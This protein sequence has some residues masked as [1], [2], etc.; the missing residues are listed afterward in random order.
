MTKHISG[1]RE[2][3]NKLAKTQEEERYPPERK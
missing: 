1:T 2:I 3:E